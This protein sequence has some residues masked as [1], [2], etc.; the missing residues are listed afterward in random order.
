[1]KLYVTLEGRAAPL[2]SDLYALLCKAAKLSLLRLKAGADGE[3]SLMLTD[4]LGIRRLNREY[5][6]IDL[7]TDVLSFPL[8][9]GQDGAAPGDQGIK[10]WGDIA[11]STETAEEQAISFGH[12]YKREMAFLTVHG[13]LHLL[14]LDHETKEERIRM[15]TLQRQILRALG[16]PRESGSL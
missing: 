2:T 14:G 7:P 1:M 9:N 6:G 4:N 15:E 5:R 10:L 11:I 12:S 3:I 13:I 16:V 8:L